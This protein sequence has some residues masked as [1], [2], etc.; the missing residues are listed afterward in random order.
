MNEAGSASRYE[1]EVVAW[2][3]R[4]N[5]EEGK[6]IL[7]GRAQVA[8]L[9]HAVLDQKHLSRMVVRGVE[10]V[11]SVLLWFVLAHNLM[12]IRF[13]RQRRAQAMAA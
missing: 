1:P 12:R 9:V 4:M 6:K 10:K 2:L 11:R 7:R 5:T 13:L 8:E 3:E